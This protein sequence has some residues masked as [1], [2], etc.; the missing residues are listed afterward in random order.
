MVGALFRSAW[1]CMMLAC[2]AFACSGE[3]DEGRNMR[4]LA[5][6]G[7]VPADALGAELHA[8]AKEAIPRHEVE[9]GPDGVYWRG[10]LRTGQV[11]DHAV[12]LVGTHCYSFL[13]VGQDTITD[14]DLILIDPNGAAIMHDADDGKRAAV[15]ISERVCPFNPG[16]YEIRVRVFAGEGEYVLRVYKYQII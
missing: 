8:W 9:G 3:A 1:F 5:D 15:G 10:E 11:E 7:A 2:G 16:A 6:H 13:A 14:L 4:P 12:I